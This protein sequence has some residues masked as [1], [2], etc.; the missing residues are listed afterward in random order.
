M[1]EHS[2]IVSER[3]SPLSITS[4]SPS[5][6][7]LNARVVLPIYNFTA[8]SVKEQAPARRLFH[9]KSLAN[10][11]TRKSSNFN[12][13]QTSLTGSSEGFFTQWINPSPFHAFRP[14]DSGSYYSRMASTTLTIPLICDSSVASK[15]ALRN[16]SS[17]RC[18]MQ[19][20]KSE[21]MSMNGVVS[22]G[23]SS[24][25]IR[26]TFAHF[27]KRRSVELLQTRRYSDAPLAVLCFNIVDP[28]TLESVIN[29]V[30]YCHRSRGTC[31]E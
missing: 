7:N 15:S 4:S 25:A 9:R 10:I 1:P 28:T 19:N 29:K 13:L 3:L 22:D 17:A 11:L 14:Q 27:N 16:W 31:N 6:T 21:D 8:D 5:T 30:C 12:L 24:R 20:D 23:N 18:N 2:S 26:A